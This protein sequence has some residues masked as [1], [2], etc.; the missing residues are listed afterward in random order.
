VKKVLPSGHP[1][2]SYSALFPDLPLHLQNWTRNL[3][4]RLSYS[5]FLHLSLDLLQ[6]SAEE[7]VLG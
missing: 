7:L 3:P 2:A 4:G 1:S 6:P 5:Y